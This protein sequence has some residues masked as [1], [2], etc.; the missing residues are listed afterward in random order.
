MRTP[1]PWRS[2]GVGIL[3]GLTIGVAETLKPEDA[4]FICRAVNS[5]DDL[6]GAAK[7][8]VSNLTEKTSEIF[9]TPRTRLAILALQKAIAAAEKSSD[10][11]G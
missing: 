6:L 2:T 3:S 1:I 4:E 5:H 8:A 7:A 9:D 10:V 11:K